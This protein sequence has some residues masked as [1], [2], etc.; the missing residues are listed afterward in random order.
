MN[1][2]DIC[3]SSKYFRGPTSITRLLADP[4]YENWMQQIGRV[5]LLPSG[6]EWKPWSACDWERMRLGT[7]R[8]DPM[9][10]VREHPIVIWNFEQSCQLQTTPVSW[11]LP[12][13]EVGSRVA[14]GITGS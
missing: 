13:S 5:F 11:P 9:R 10:Q 7:A 2:L 14:F 6:I 3:D 8:V 1:A 12:F 4:K